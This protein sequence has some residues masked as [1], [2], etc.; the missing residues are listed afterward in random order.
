MGQ[1]SLLTLVPEHD[2][3]LMLVTNSATGRRFNP[4]VTSVA[5]KSYLG[6]ETP[7]HVIMDIPEDELGEYAGEYEAKLSAVT[8]T[9]NEGGLDLSQRSL[10]GFPTADDKPASTEPSPPES[11]VF[12]L[13]DQI[14]GTGEA[15]RYT[16]AQFIR[17]DEGNVAWIRSCMRLHKRT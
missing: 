5:L 13:K 9:V 1:I 14:T 4:P 8:V 7:E 3:G 12:Y 10:G 2:F 15:N 16:I 11:F 17:D 6:V